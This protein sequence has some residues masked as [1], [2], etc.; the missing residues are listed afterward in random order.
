VYAAL[1]SGQPGIQPRCRT[2]LSGAVRSCGHSG[3][4]CAVDRS[5]RHKKRVGQWK[6]EMSLPRRSVLHPT[7]P[8]SGRER[9]LPVKSPRQE[10]R[11]DSGAVGTYELNRQSEA[12]CAA[13]GCS[14][15]DAFGGGEIRQGGAANSGAGRVQWRRGCLCST[16]PVRSDSEP[17][18]RACGYSGWRCSPS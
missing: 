17:S 1:L 12:S 9:E 15:G 7:H 11:W 13:V 2:I 16:G 10:S 3:V 4:V 8:L 18:V 5:R 6:F 14:G